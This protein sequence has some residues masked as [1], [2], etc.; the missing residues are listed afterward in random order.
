[1]KNYIVKIKVDDEDSLYNEYDPDKLTLNDSLIQYIYNKVELAVLKDNIVIEIESDSK[2]DEKK[3]DKA[4]DSYFENEIAECNA[5]IEMNRRREL[6][7]LIIGLIFIIIS[8]IIGQES[9]LFEICSIIGSF[10]IWTMLDI[11]LMNSGELRIRKKKYLKL[12]Q[13]KQVYK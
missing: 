12:L 10:S 2:L 9:L 3:L 6:W 4:F 5:Y 7:M 13:S 8:L 11:V 1:M